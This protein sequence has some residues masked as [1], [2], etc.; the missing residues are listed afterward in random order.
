MINEIWRDFDEDNNGFLD[1]N[2]TYNFTMDFMSQLGDDSQKISDNNFH[3]IFKIID[4]DNS[5]QIDKDEMAIFVAQL[6]ALQKE[7]NFKQ[8]KIKVE[9]FK[10][11][12]NQ[13]R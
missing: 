13:I 3:K 4:R 9:N 2:E 6:R 1:F 8:G 10:E 12:G 11:L 5:G 7:G